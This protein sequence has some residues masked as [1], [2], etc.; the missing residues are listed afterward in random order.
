[1]PFY[2]FEF[3]TSLSPHEVTERLRTR[4]RAPRRFFESI[5]NS[6]RLGSFLPSKNLDQPLIGTID[7]NTFRVRRDIHYRNSFLPLVRGR[8]TPTS[9]GSHISVKMFIHP[10]RCSILNNLV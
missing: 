1:M 8:I 7:N 6:F 4:I 10:P 9:T 2:Q 5:R 3:D